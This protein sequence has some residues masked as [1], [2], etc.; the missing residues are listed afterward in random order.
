M[1]IRL[2]LGV[3][4]L[5]IG[6]LAG[7]CGVVPRSTNPPV[8][9]VSKDTA[10]S[11]EPVST[12]PSSSTKTAEKGK[13]ES[14]APPSDSTPPPSM[15]VTSLSEAKSSLMKAYREWKGTPYQIGGESSKGVDCSRFM[16]IVFEDYLGIDLPNNT[17]T[18][19]NVGKG[20]RRPGIRTGDLVFFKT[21]R[22]TLHVGVAVN[23]GEFLHASTSNGVMISK[24]GNSYWRDRFLAARRVL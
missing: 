3:I 15:A 10:S 6:M 14:E 2:Q 21:G 22:K 11:P 1:M 19:L 16:E 23:R 8:T 20:I 24:L 5:L 17:R 12:T 9:T 4:I 18:Q 7:G 13:K